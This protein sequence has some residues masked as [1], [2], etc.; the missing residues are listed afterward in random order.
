MSLRLHDN[1][2]KAN[3]VHHIFSVVQ[4]GRLMKIDVADM[5]ENGFHSFHV[6]M[7]VLYSLFNKIDS[8]WVEQR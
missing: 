7:V 3:L 8:I 6:A 1:L 2:E 5:F 4:T